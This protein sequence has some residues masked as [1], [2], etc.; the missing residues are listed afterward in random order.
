[1]TLERLFQEFRCSVVILVHHKKESP[2]HI[3]PFI[4]DAIDGLEK[5]I[6]EIKK[7]MLQ[8]E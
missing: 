2:P 3:H 1:M 4:D 6:A 5:A 7:L 8:Q